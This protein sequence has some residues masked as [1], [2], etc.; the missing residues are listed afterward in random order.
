[1]IYYLIIYLIYYLVNFLWLSI[2]EDEYQ[3]KEIFYLSF[4]GPALTL[5]VI[6]VIKDRRFKKYSY[7][8]KG[9]N[10]GN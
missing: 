4:L 1:M 10:H 5:M 3:L 7:I 6:L 2:I 9:L 8:L